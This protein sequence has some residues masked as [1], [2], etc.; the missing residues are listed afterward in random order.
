MIDLNEINRDPWPTFPVN[1]DDLRSLLDENARLRS[2]IEKPQLSLAPFAVRFLW[3]D[4][5]GYECADDIRS[6]QDWD[7][8]AND[9]QADDVFIL[10]RDIKRA[11]EALEQGT[12]PR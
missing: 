9:M 1:K 4:D 8:D 5:L 11:R 12:P 3:P 6:D 7:E 10:R 2:Q